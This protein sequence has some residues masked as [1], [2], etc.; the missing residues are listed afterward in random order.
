M[1]FKKMIYIVVI[2]CINKLC[3]QYMLV[4]MD[5][6]QTNHLKAYGIA[7]WI[8][9]KDVTAE[10]LLNFRGGSFLFTDSEL[11]ENE[12]RL[13]GVHYEK[14]NGATVNQIYAEIENNNMERILLEKAPKIAVYS[15]PGYQ[16]WDDAVTLALT[17]A[18]IDYDIVYDREVLTD[19]LDDYDWLHLHHEDFTGQYGKFWGAF[20]HESWYIKQQAEAEKLANELGYSKVSKEK[21]DVARTIK[22]YVTNGGF[23]FAMCSAADALD[24]A[25]SAENTDICD[26]VFD[27]DPIDPSF[28]SKLDYNECL[29]FENFRLITNPAIYEFSDIDTPPSN[30]PRLRDPDTDYFTLF[31]FSAKYD[32]VPTM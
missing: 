18:E 3:A 8:L 7:Y 6:K 16:P 17:Y 22:K 28:E 2:L 24:I 13:R 12:C 20:R 30:M 11:F 31:E 15:P 19:K 26:V 21:G 9:K 27:G 1:M 23:L 29:A 10:W 4:P 32:P 25:L 14:V 5:L